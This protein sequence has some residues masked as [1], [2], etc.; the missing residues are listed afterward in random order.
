MQKI[1]NRITT[2]LILAALI[3]G[4]STLMQV[5]TTFRILGYPG[6]AIIFFSLAAGGGIALIA[7]ILANDMRARRKK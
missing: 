6:F 2:G 4:A 1:A 3:I 7:S 5:D